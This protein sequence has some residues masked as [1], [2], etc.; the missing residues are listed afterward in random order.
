LVVL[1]T[2]ELANQVH[3]VFCRLIIGSSIKILCCTGNT[4]IKEEQSLLFGYYDHSQIS[5]LSAFSTDES[6]DNYLDDNNSCFGSNSNGSRNSSSSLNQKNSFLGYNQDIIINILICTPGR[7]LEHINQTK[8][9]SLKRLRYMVLDEADRLLGNAY[10]YWVKSLIE[11]TQQ[12]KSSSFNSNDSVSISSNEAVEAGGSKRSFEEMLGNSERINSESSS[13]SSSSSI[14]NSNSGSSRGKFSEQS[15]KSLQL[16]LF[17]ATLTDNPRK[18]GMLG[19]KNPILLKL[20]KDSPM[21][22]LPTNLTESMRVCETSQRPLILLSALA[23]AFDFDHG[24]LSSGLGLSSDSNSNSNSVNNVNTKHRNLCSIGSNSMC[25]IFTSSVETTRRLCRLLQIFNGQLKDGDDANTSNSNSN[26]N[27]NSIGNLNS[28]Y[29]KGLVS[30]MSGDLTSSQRETIMTE[31]S[32]G[33][34]KILVSSDHL[35]RGI[36]LPNC[37]L[38]INY[39]APKF[40]KTYVHRVGRTARADRHGHAITLMKKG[41]QAMF[42]KM[43]SEIQAMNQLSSSAK[44]GGDLNSVVP[45]CK[46]A[47]TTMDLLTPIYSNALEQFKDSLDDTE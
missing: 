28:Y 32:K 4:S 33:K 23:E 21:Y 19:V 1:P 29:F 36:D 24:S 5:S 35:S 41:Q 16:L 30:E 44:K 22:Q 20:N 46:V 17:S 3:N 11:S 13:S 9:F 43:R 25:L 34:I 7:L 45:K 38:V 12:S 39:D 42:L 8:N 2:R 10:H 40:A 18:L 6:A 26:S 37:K 14:S 31:A 47:Q 15:R 27:R